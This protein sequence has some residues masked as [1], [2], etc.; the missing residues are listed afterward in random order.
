MLFLEWKGFPGFRIYSAKTRKFPANWD[1]L[2]T[3]KPNEIVWLTEGKQQVSKQS[4]LWNQ[5]QYNPVLAIMWDLKKGL[6]LQFPVQQA[7]APLTHQQGWRT[8]GSPLILNSSQKF[9]NFYSHSCSKILLMLSPKA[10]KI[11]GPGFMLG[12]VA[13]TLGFALTLASLLSA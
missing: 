10:P 13:F 9:Q 2:I 11:I 6:T 3:L 8:L 12:L 1:K 7:Q 4:Q 5:V